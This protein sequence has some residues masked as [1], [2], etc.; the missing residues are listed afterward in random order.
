[1]KLN[2]KE[3]AARRLIKKAIIVL[4]LFL[5]AMSLSG[6]DG[7]GR[8]SGRYVP[9]D[10]EGVFAYFE[11]DGSICRMEDTIAGVRQ[12]LPFV[13]KGN[14]VI[15]ANGAVIFRIESG[16]VLVGMGLMVD[17][18]RYIKKPSPAKS[19]SSAK[20]TIKTRDG[21][22]AVKN[23]GGKTVSIAA[24]E[25]TETN[26]QIPSKINNMPVTA[27]GGTFDE[28]EEDLVLVV[29]GLRFSYEQ[30]EKGEYAFAYKGL[31]GVTIPNSV[32][33]IGAQAF[34]EN[35]LI[36]ITIGANVQIGENAF[37]RRTSFITYY[38]NQGKKAGTYVKEGGGWTL[39]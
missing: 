22:V 5:H 2:R 4:G 37:D 19:A 11:F 28:E 14:Q 33:T 34:Y 17:D 30:I 7:A 29:G 9:E 15:V 24:Y 36:Q 16:D 12:A 27:I 13:V 23:T 25:G 39:K 10:D 1:M 38:A 35:R 31:I 6:C 18:I 20:D 3:F 32:T 21:F 8:V 26:V